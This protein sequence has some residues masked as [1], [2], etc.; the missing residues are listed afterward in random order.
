MMRIATLKGNQLTKI[1][2]LERE[3]GT[4]VVAFE[5][6]GKFANLSADQITKLQKVEEELGLL[7][8]ASNSA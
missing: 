8:L 7:L 6:V 1:Q 3:F 2:E 4:G 5:P